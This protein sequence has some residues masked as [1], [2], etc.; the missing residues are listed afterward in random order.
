MKLNRNSLS[1]LS[2][3]ALA[4]SLGACSTHSVKSDADYAAI[5]D[6]YNQLDQDNS[7]IAR[8]ISA[9]GGGPGIDLLEKVSDKF[10][11]LV[12]EQGV[13]DTGDKV[14]GDIGKQLGFE[15]LTMANLPKELTEPEAEIA[16]KMMEKAG[17]FE[18]PG[19]ESLRADAHQITDHMYVD[20]TGTAGSAAGI[21]KQ[22][23]LFDASAN[24]KI[25]LADRLRSFWD[26]FT[27]RAFKKNISQDRTGDTYL[28]KILNWAKHMFAESQ[29]EEQEF[30][31]FTCQ[32]MNEKGDGVLDIT[33]MENLE[34]AYKVQSTD[35]DKTFNEMAMKDKPRTSLLNKAFNACFRNKAV[36]DMLAYIRDK[37]GVTEFKAAQARLLNLIQV[38]HIMSDD[39]IPVV[40]GMTGF[41]SLSTSCSM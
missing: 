15:N 34:G 30:T 8:K 32:A 19:F 16:I 4:L 24:T 35:M 27:E 28:K 6:A 18:R 3:L 41:G 1:I 31:D 12:G 10:L 20:D 29:G 9:L 17:I 23:H 25:P 21:D 37:L 36:V 7:F 14:C 22:D 39:M 2:A 26:G 33:A 38:C 13:K 40:N 5:N 11:A